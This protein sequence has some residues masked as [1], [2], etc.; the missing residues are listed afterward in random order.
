MTSRPAIESGMKFRPILSIIGI[1]ALLWRAGLGLALASPG[2]PPSTSAQPDSIAGSSLADVAVVDEPPFWDSMIMHNESV[3]MISS[4]GGLPE[5]ALLFE[6]IQI[7]SVR[8]SHLDVTYA[9]G[10]DWTYANGVLKLTAGSSAP[11]MTAAEL[12]PTSAI[13]GWTQNKVGG[14]YVLFQEGTYFHDRQLAVTYTHQR[15]AWH[16][17]VSTYDQAALPATANRLATG[18]PLKIVLYGDS[19]SVGANASGLFGTAPNMS[20]WGELVSQKLRAHSTSSIT[21]ANPSVGGTTSAWGKDNAAAL[22]VP[23]SPDLVIIA[24]GMNDISLAPATYRQNIEAIINTVSA[25]RPTCEFILI[26]P[27]LPNPETYF[28]G[29]QAL[30]LTQLNLLAGTGRAV[31]NMTTVHA[32]LL[33]HKRYID[34]TGNNVNHPNDFL[35]RW[36]FQMVSSL[37]LEKTVPV[38]LSSL[39]ID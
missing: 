8:N 26:A 38:E 18:L 22:V 20:T 14:G 5:A 11:S 7:L 21:L 23:Q 31:V 9:E 32:E 12:Y 1:S 25:A 28:W 4:N 6:P 10:V 27:M 30:F 35:I 2:G 33:L 39:E 16:G 29:N 34:I 3:M 15:D 17:V 37:L 24:F 36:Y 13:P 19:I